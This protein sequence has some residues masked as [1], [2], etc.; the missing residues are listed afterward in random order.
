MIFLSH[1]EAYSGLKFCD[2]DFVPIFPD[3]WIPSF[4]Y[5]ISMIFL[6]H[7][8]AYSRLKFCDSDFVPICPDLWIPSFSYRISLIFFSLWRRLF[9]F[10]PAE[11]SFF[12]IFFLPGRK[13][14]WYIFHPGRKVLWCS[15]FREEG[16]LIFFGR[17]E[18]LNA[19]PRKGVFLLFFSSWGEGFF[20][21]YLLGWFFWF[22]S[23]RVR[24]CEFPQLGRKAF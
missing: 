2:S 12:L 3:L 21:F 20:D 17:K 11:E 9:D 10:F 7:T 18:F 5:G 6:S 22:C 15:R 8:E 14:F 4:S 23:R 1:T 16:L 24:F 19:L 13:V